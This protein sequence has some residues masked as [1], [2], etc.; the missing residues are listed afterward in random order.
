MLLLL[1]L[2]QNLLSQHHHPI[3]FWY[4]SW[5]LGYEALGCI[6][7]KLSEWPGLSVHWGVLEQRSTVLTIWEPVFSLSELWGFWLRSP[8]DHL[9]TRQRVQKIDVVLGRLLS[10]CLSFLSRGI[11]GYLQPCVGIEIW[12]RDRL[13]EHQWWSQLHGSKVLWPED[14]RDHLR[15]SLK[16]KGLELCHVCFVCARDRKDCGFVSNRS[17]WHKQLYISCGCAVLTSSSTRLTRTTLTSEIRSPS[18]YVFLFNHQNLLNIIT[19][20]YHV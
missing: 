15:W 11:E 5:R 2:F 9:W 1:T 13:L 6:D 17:T 16:R 20:K 14:L 4:W 19:N 10:T 3:W 18:A 8:G 7:E 12:H